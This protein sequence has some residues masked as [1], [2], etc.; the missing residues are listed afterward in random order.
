MHWFKSDLK[1]KRNLLHWFQ[2]NLK[3]KVESIRNWHEANCAGRQSSSVITKARD[4]LNAALNVLMPLQPE[5][6]AC[7]NMTP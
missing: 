6:E 1:L 4:D 3:S 7:E 5:K 2:F